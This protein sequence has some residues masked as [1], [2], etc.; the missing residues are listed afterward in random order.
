M[1][2]H[3]QATTSYDHLRRP[4]P[5]AAMLMA[6]FA[7]FAGGV[8]ASK[9]NAAPAGKANIYHADKSPGEAALAQM[10]KHPSVLNIKLV[11][12][13]RQIGDVT[14]YNF[15]DQPI[16]DRTY[17]FTPSLGLHESMVVMHPRWTK[18]HQGHTWI[19]ANDYRNATVIDPTT[20]EADS[21]RFGRWLRADKLP[22][23]TLL[24]KGAAPT[25]KHHLAGSVVMDADDRGD[26]ALH[27]HV[28]GLSDYNTAILSKDGETVDQIRR[29]E[30]DQVLKDQNFLHFLAHQ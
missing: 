5:N 25:S 11:I 13:A 9:A 10:N 1:R 27:L 17:W 8:G 4:S 21:N 16:D 22:K 18:D 23:G 29:F 15:Q 3:D 12:P 30:A 7:I 14:G 6:A 2:T 28:P 19:F 20:M 24:L 26:T